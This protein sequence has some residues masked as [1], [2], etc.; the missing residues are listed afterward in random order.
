MSKKLSVASLQ[1]RLTSFVGRAGELIELERLL[2]AGPLVTVTGVG[3]VGKSRLVLRAA[4]D[5]RPNFPDGVYVVELAPLY[6]EDLL[7]HVIATTIMLRD[8]PRRSLTELLVEYVER[9]RMLLVLDN[10]DAFVRPCADLVERLLPEAPGLRILLTSR[11][12]LGIPVE[13]VLRLA[14]FSVPV[15]EGPD[16]A[17]QSDAV[18]L[19]ADRAAAARKGFALTAANAQEAATLCR[20][21][22]GIP[23]AIELA[24]AQLHALPLDQI[25]GR[26]DRRLSLLRSTSNGSPLRHQTLRTTVGWSHELCEAEERLLWCRLSVFPGDFDG[27]AAAAVCADSEL[28]PAQIPGLLSRLVNKS[29]LAAAPEAGVVRYQMLDT[30][31]EYG[32]EWLSALGEHQKL[33]GSY[34]D[35]YIGLAEDFHAD[36]FG[37]RQPEWTRRMRTEQHNLLAALDYCL[38]GQDK[39]RAGQRL[40]GALY[41]FWYAC[42][43]LRA[44]RYWLERT[45]AADPAPSPDRMRVL[46]AYGR[47]LLIQGDVEALVPPAR[48]CLELARQFSD[49][50]YESHALH[51]LGL[52]LLYRDDPGAPALL[53]QAVHRASDLGPDHPALAYTKFALAVAVLV[54]GDP[55]GAEALLAESEEICRA[56]G[57][58]WWLGITQT[59][60]IHPALERGDIAQAT[61]YARNS[62][63]VRRVLEDRH[64]TVSSLELLG[65]VAAAAHDYTRAARLLGATDRHWRAAGGSPFAVGYFRDAHVRWETAT[66]KALGE[67]RYEREFSRGAALTLDDAISYALTPGPSAADSETEK[68]PERSTSCD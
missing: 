34:L 57:D 37:P 36:W 47:M 11:Q 10:C 55:A 13:R 59:T 4:T 19:F 51:T 28:P 17:M 7:C 3:G 22:D 61:A 14:P 42:G 18:A 33:A 2:E 48:E 12:P 32:A 27:A 65:W 62:M 15:A 43:E 49:S 68:L 66:R 64:G 9:K 25:A 60:A 56:R 46:G 54:H 63:H 44:G 38:T 26:L 30:V 31:R 58:R 6:D 67:R 41:Y 39:A 5:L 29:I 16:D 21:L 53:E 45:L 20:R 24:A 23:L 8:D 35:Y 1:T 52:G 50:F 40:A